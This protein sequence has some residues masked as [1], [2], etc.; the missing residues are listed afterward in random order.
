MKVIIRE[1]SWIARLA[2]WKLGTPNVALVLGSTI[3]LHNVS[4][5]DFLKNERWVRHEMCHV[6]QFQRFGYFNFLIRYLW[7]S[8]RHGYRNNKYEVEARG[9]EGADDQAIVSIS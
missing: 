8:I 7:E 9:C 2:A 3:H 5:V 4:K 1:K 6:R